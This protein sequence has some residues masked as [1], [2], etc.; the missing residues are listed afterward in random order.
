ME[1]CAYKNPESTGAGNICHLQLFSRRHVDHLTENLGAVNV[2]LTEQDM[3]Y[4]EAARSKIAT[5]GEIM[6]PQ[7]MTQYDHSV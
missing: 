3:E 6:S 5:H 4:I 1:I 7:H 2:G